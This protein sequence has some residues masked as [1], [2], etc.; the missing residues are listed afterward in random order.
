M[1][2]LTGRVLLFV[3]RSLDA[4]AATARKRKAGACIPSALL[5]PSNRS[6]SL[7]R[8]G[9]KKKP[10]LQPGDC[11]HIS[12]RVEFK[13]DKPELAS[14]AAAATAKDPTLG[15]P[16]TKTQASWLAKEMNTMTPVCPT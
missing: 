16:P 12:F 5:N 11:G 6:H 3:N 9:S 8:L 1:T 7:L 13:P 10:K 2:R 4:Q 14:A 15:T